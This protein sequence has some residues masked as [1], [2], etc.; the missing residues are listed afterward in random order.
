MKYFYPHAIAVLQVVWQSDPD[1]PNPATEKP[2]KLQ[3]QPRVTKVS[4]NSYVE[5]DTFEIELD[6]KTFPFDP[7]TMRSC[8]VTIYMANLDT[9]SD[10]LNAFQPSADNAVFEGFADEDSIEL[11]DSTRT[12]RLKGRDF[13]A[14]L[15]DAKW[16]GKLLPLNQPLD[17]V[18]GGLFTQLPTMGNIEIDNR[19]GLLVLPTLAEFYPD[20]AKLAALRSAKRHEKYWDVIQDLCTRCGVIGYFEQGVFVLTKPRTLYDASKAIQFIY[21]KNIKSLEMTRKF[22]RQKGFNLE[23]RSINGKEVILAEIPKE[24]KNLPEGGDYVYIPVQTPQGVMVN[25]ANPASR[26]PTLSFVVANVNSKSHL[27][28]VGEK[29]YEEIGRQQIEGKIKTYDM[30][31][32][33]LSVDPENAASGESNCFDLLKMRNATPIKI[34]IN[35]DDLLAISAEKSVPRRIAYL[36]HRGYSKDVAV[37]FA[38]TLGKFP[39][40]FYTKAVMYTLDAQSGLTIEIDFINF[41]ETNKKG[42]SI[43]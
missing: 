1:S 24:S 27:I 22:G 17:A 35:S 3:V 18:I 29:I 16:P 40:P 39:T 36:T 28:E 9:M 26:A 20:Y 21:G 42:L 25:K 6:Y 31:A 30:D 41:I 10:P 34:Q 13:T 37:L 32:P 23:V 43:L 33:A 2:Y 8:Q 11:N 12:V 38:D 19:T 5:A 15:I 7:R 14:L 4:I